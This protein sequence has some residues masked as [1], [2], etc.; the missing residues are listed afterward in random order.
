MLI[1]IVIRKLARSLQYGLYTGKT[2]NYEQPK[3]IRNDHRDPPPLH[4]SG[5]CPVLRI[6]NRWHQHRPRNRPRSFVRRLTASLTE[7]DFIMT[8]S[9]RT[10]LFSLF[11]AIVCAFVTIGTSVAPAISPSVT[12]PTAQIA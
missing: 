5:S 2:R 11:A 3:G 4:C 7:K 8:S 1:F 10:Q 6:R 9:S 12:A